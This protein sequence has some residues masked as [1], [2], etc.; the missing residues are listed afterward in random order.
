MIP[1]AIGQW[2][3]KIRGMVSVIVITPFQWHATVPLAI[4]VIKQGL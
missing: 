1:G 2:L 4:N 3:Y